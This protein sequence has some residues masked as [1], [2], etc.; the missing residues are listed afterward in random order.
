MVDGSICSEWE[1]D[2]TVLFGYQ[3]EMDWRYNEEHWK[4]CVG[5]GECNI[6]T[7]KIQKMPNK[8]TEICVN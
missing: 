2:S 6:I 3:S 4:S 8:E 1:A 7:L 5:K